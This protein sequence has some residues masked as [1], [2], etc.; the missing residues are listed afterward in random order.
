MQIVI[1]VLFVLIVTIV[2]LIQKEKQTM[3][4]INL[5]LMA[6]YEGILG[7]G[8]VNAKGFDAIPFAIAFVGIGGIHLLILFILALT[9][10]QPVKQPQ[11]A[12]A[13]RPPANQPAVRKAMQRLP[14]Q[15]RARVK[16]APKTVRETQT[17]SIATE[18]RVL[19]TR[20]QEL[21]HKLDDR[22]GG[23]LPF[24]S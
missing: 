21:L 20:T 17:Q 11:S 7:V 18:N 23:E 12:S 19:D 14:E 4:F 6:V 5:L 13:N 8:I 1:V 22:S 15:D 16:P 24:D 3:L 9:L 10:P 2:K